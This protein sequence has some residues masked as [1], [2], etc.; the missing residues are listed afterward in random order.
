MSR[1]LASLLRWILQRLGW[2]A[3]I[4]AV[5]LAGSWVAGEWRER[6]RLRAELETQAAAVEAR[7]REIDTELRDLDARIERTQHAWR[8]ATARLADVERQAQD[9]RRAAEEARARYRALERQSTWWNLLLDPGRIVELEQARARYLALDQAARA[10]ETA[11]DRVEPRFRDSPVAGLEAERESRLGELAALESLLAGQRE[12]LE[13]DPRER[14]AAAVRAQLPAALAILAGLILAPVLVKALFYFV[15]APLAQALPPVRILPGGRAPLPPPP[16]PSAV[17]VAIEVGP[18]EELLVQPDF[19]Q[20]SSAVA[21]KRTQWFL[22]ARLPF[23]SLASG[24]VLL[25]RIGP[26]GTAPTRVVVSPRREPLDEV[27]VLEL[28]AGAA[29]ILQPR[30]LVGVVKPAG[31]PVAVTRHWRLASLHAWLTLQ[32]RYLAFHGPC[33]LVLRGCRGVRAEQP[34][35]GR[36]RVVNQSA[37]LGFSAGLEYRNTR[38]ETFVPYLRGQ[39]DLLNDM[40]SGGPGWFVYEEMPAARRR[41]GITGRGLEGVADAFLKA[42]GI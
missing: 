24:L 12:R 3:V 14:L 27:T 19:I 2:L 11:R 30:S 39:E 34:E 4:L 26:D 1:L 28:P 13:S 5:L 16:G 35:P 23:S 41:A 17:S 42:F 32:L 20:S 36:P 25:T 40:F 21:P 22:D 10:W 29:M 15:L 6:E 8:D 7:R 38:C 31:T 9:A 18:S 33:R 37:T